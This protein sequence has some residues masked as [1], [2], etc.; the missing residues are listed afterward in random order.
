[1]K[2]DRKDRLEQ[3]ILENREGFD[4]LEPDYKVLER[5]QKDLGSDKKSD[6][7]FNFNY[8][9]RAAAVILLGVSAFLFVERQQMMDPERAVATVEDINPEFYEAEGY[10]IQMI[11]EKSAVIREYQAEY[12]DL[13]QDFETDIQKLDEM[14]ANLKDELKKENTEQVVD[15]LIQNLQLRID[16]LNQQ[17]MILENIRK[18][19]NNEDV[20]I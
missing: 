14:Y 10:F 8:V 16:V 1:M 15:A 13:I 17:L 4:H 20:T 9:W 3:F 18:A 6:G 19:Q 2:Q 12:P 5:I 7:G 11:N